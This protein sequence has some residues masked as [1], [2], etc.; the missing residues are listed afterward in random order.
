M[1]CGRPR[2]HP[3]QHCI[4]CGKQF[5]RAHADRPLQRCRKCF[6]ISTRGKPKPRKDRVLHEGYYMKRCPEHPRAGKT[7]YVLEH[8]L[9]MEKVLGRYLAPVEV[10]HHFNGNTRD[11]RPE[12]LRLCASS[13]EHT[14]QFHGRR[15]GQCCLC[16]EQA[17]HRGFC[18]NH[19]RKVKQR[20]KR[21]PH[22]TWSDFATKRVLIKPWSPTG[23]KRNANGH[24]IFHT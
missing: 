13:S 19:Y 21:W 8:R 1:K 11:N 6:Y 24:I 20:L 22:L 10:V 16:A 14:K 12:N 23:V 18:R 17:T 7:G 3:I 4:D 5:A 2:I 9:V 15:L